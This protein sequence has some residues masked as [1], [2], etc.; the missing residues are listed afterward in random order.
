MGQASSPLT[1]FSSPVNGELPA[2]FGC[3]SNSPKLVPSQAQIQTRQGA[4]LPIT[5]VAAWEGYPRLPP[6]LPQGPRES[7]G[8]WQARPPD[9]ACEL[10]A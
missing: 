4:F 9:A 6:L 7:G 1:A 5:A 2:R 10:R 8:P 3:R